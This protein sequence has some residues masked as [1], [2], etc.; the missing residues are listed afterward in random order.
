MPSLLDSRPVRRTPALF[1]QALVAQRRAEQDALNRQQ[2][3]GEFAVRE[4]RLAEQAAVAAAQRDKALALRERALA[5]TDKLKDAQLTAA[6]SQLS[7]KEK[8][9]SAFTKAMKTIGGIAADDA[10]AEMKI[11]SVLADN[12]A[13]L[14]EDNAEL[15]GMLKERVGSLQK[16][17]MDHRSV[18]QKRD[19]EMEKRRLAGEQAN[20]AVGLGMK[21][22]SINTSTGGIQFKAPETGTEKFPT[23]ED[24][25]KK[26]PQAA[27]GGVTLPTGEFV[28]ERIGSAAPKESAASAMMGG[29][30]AASAAAPAQ[31]ATEPKRIRA[32]LV[33]GQLVLAE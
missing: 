31:S 25:R 21:P 24:A 33:D 29:P 20:A 10:D 11:A 1:G 3:Q 18:L 26:Y 16:N 17:I 28:L 8:Q 7:R 2:K 23:Y 5:I 15:S 22:E 13:A 9:V 14:D 12:A 6:E 32:K 27:I 4:G 19:E 30:S